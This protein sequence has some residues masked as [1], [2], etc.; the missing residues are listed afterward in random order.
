MMPGGVQGGVNTAF[1]PRMAVGLFGILL[2]AMVAGL[3][4]RVP[5]L[6]LADVR[7]ALG[8]ARDD[9]SWITTVYTAGE[10]AVVPFATWFALTFSLRRMHCWTLGIMLALSALLPLAQN[11]PVLLTLRAL[12]GV[13]AGALI[14]VLMMAALRFLPPPIRLH[15]LALF[16]MSAT[17]SPN[18]A[19]WLAAL[20]VDR[21]EDWR[22][23]FWHTIPL[24]LVAMALVGWGIPKMP[25][26]TARLQQANWPGMALGMPGLALVAVGVDQGVRLDWLHSPLIMGALGAGG[27]LS[28]LF[29]YSEWHHPAPFVRPQLLERRNLLL[30]CAIL[31][32]LLMTL[33]S[34]VSL[35]ANILAQTQGF[36][37]AQTAPL[38]LIVGLPQVLL[39]SLVALLLYQRWVDARLLLALGL[40]CIAV[41][42]WQ[43]S[44]LS[45]VWMV[46]QFL[47]AE[48]LQAIGQPLAV[49]SMLYLGT[50][51]VAPMEGAFVAG[52]MNIFR[53]SGMVFGGALVGQMTALRSRF[54]TEMLLDRAA[55]LLPGLNASGQDIGTLASTVA[56]Q[57]GVLAAADI[58]RLFAVLSLLLIPVAL[59]MKHIP[60]PTLNPPPLPQ[61]SSPLRPAVDG[62]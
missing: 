61:A 4:G 37:M 38:G 59:S 49:V 3:C 34:G 32:C 56:S 23:A 28:L 22:W 50:S 2:A 16:A 6:V 57:A 52:I 33:S 62:H 27:V 43:A 54:H 18:V 10:L 9:A 17:F 40:L 15:G 44:H 21:L 55:V 42:C 12:Q 60:A 35:P 20:C 26:A 36:R 30:G 48:V 45:Q 47:P 24:G 29:L 11:L 14:P 31:C 51:V 13:F 58:Y 8:L 25:M 39:G 53:V 41:A 19:L 5:G 46:A 7:G 1:G